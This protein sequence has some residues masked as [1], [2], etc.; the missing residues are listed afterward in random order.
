MSNG[1][2]VYLVGVGMTR[3][4]IHMER[5]V[6]SLCEEALYEAMVDA[7]AYPDDIEAGYLGTVGLAWD[8][9]MMGG[10]IAFE[11]VGITG[12]PITRVENACGS[13][14]NAIREAWIGIKAGLY[15]VA[16]AAGVEIMN[17]PTR[18]QIGSLSLL[19]GGDA[20]MEGTQGFFPPGIFA[21]VAQAYIE[22]GWIERKDLAVISVKNAY[23][24]S[25]NPKAHFQ[26][27]ITIDQVLNARTISYPLGLLD[28][29]P[30]TDGA[31]A[32]VLCSEKALPRFKKH[33]PVRVKWMSQRSGTYCEGDPEMNADTTKL[34]VQDAYKNTGLGP[35]DIDFIECHD[36]FTMAEICHV[37]DLGFCE[38]E[39]VGKVVRS[40]YTQLDGK[41]PFNVSGGLMSK[42]HPLG[43]TGPAQYYE[44][45]QQLRGE[46]G[47]RQVKD[48]R[49]GLQHNGG[50]FRHGDTG[51]V[52]ISIMEKTD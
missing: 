5:D 2:D 39:E 43:A 48:A 21:M 34:A 17:Q 37:H 22:K 32:V 42:G 50:G 26:R 6:R 51:I 28:C 33:A 8:V 18:E 49:I 10:Q 9:P 47:K 16:M 29:C 1:N 45:A 35:E 13:G 30:T 31:A 4:G 44:M 7:G 25:M 15:D 46:A 52:V 27:T 3:F 24:G 23:H 40:G 38:K 11:Q 19:G 12:V 14:S 41:I 36:C 20:L